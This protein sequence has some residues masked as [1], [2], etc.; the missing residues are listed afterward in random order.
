[1][2]QM[3]TLLLDCAGLNLK[4]KLNFFFFFFVAAG[5]IFLLHYTTVV[6]LQF[7][8]A[9]LFRLLCRRDRN[10]EKYYN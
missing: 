10:I 3:F 9:L 5:G 7:N 2:L 1:M 6:V 8:L 4:K